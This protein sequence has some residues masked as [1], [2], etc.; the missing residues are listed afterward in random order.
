VHASSEGLAT[1]VVERESIGGQ[2]SSSSLIRNYLGFARGVGGAE[3]AQR[4]YQQ[5]WGF[6]TSFLLT[7]DVVGLKP[8]PG[9]HVLDVAGERSVTARAVVLA[10]GVSYR[11]IGIPALERLTGAGVFYGASVSE[12]RGLVGE[13]VYVIGG[14]NSAGQ[15][16]MH[17]ARYASRVRI[18][19]RDESLADSMSQYLQD[20]IEAAGNVEVLLGTEVVDGEGDGCLERLVLRHRPSGRTWSADAAALFVLIGAHPNTDWLPAS[21]E[22][23]AWGYVCTGRD[24]PGAAPPL[25]LETSVR[26]VF[27]VGDVR[28][29]AVKRVASAV[30]EGSVAIQQVHQSL[31]AVQ[32]AQ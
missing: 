26:G 2:A 10:M 20:A 8:D 27:A 12:A 28:Q 17:L 24:V 9:M 25:M 23:D 19:V 1:L 4:A 18:V 6:G 14:G 22:R 31:A 29:G 7:R 15:S 11:R 13:E 16:A 32:V 3:L 5:A 30:G 21:I